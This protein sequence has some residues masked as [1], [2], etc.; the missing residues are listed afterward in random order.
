MNNKYIGIFDSGIGGLTVAKA[1]MEALPKENI[2]Y[3]GDTLNSPYGDK[4][5][6]QIIELVKQDAKFLEQFDLK[7]LVIACNTADAIG[8]STITKMYD[9][10]V[11]GVVGPA[12]KYTCSISKNKKIGVIATKA[13]INSK[14]YEKAI[15]KIDENV[16]VYSNACPLLVPLVE[17]GKFTDDC[18]ETKQIL[19]GYLKPLLEKGIDS[20]ILGCT[21]YPLLTNM[22]RQIAPNINI[23]SSS[24]AAAEKIK[25][26][27]TRL[28][29]LSDELI[30]RQFYVSSNPEGFTKL[31]NIFIE[32]FNY[33]VKLK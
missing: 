1:I 31:A 29:M 14:A 11:F 21:H 8:R 32:N 6:E 4:K 17:Q 16:K 15:K 7:A 28:N 10:P 25:T 27:L 9:T 30:K 19:A 20:L 5:E 2:V 13:A 24:E 3:F 22:V 23:I 33:D 18:L 26:D 12:S